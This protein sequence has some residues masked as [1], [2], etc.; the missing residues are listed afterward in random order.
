MEE[1]LVLTVVKVENEMENAVIK[2]YSANTGIVTVSVDKKQITLTGVAPG[3]TVIQIDCIAEVEVS[4]EDEDGNV[5]TKTEIFKAEPVVCT[6]QVK[7]NPK[8]DKTNV[9]KD[10]EGREVYVQENGTYRLA[11]YADYYAHS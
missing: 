1:P 10:N 11:Y 3:E 4:E 8:L 6:V 5:T 2:A 7:A 9:L